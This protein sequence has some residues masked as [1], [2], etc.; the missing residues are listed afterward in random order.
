MR[1]QT[2]PQTYRATVWLT[3]K[4]RVSFLFNLQVILKAKHAGR[5]LG[6]L[7]SACHGSKRRS[8][9]MKLSQMYAEKYK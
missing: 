2:N 3:K 6:Y 7:H 5:E 4:K 8:A 1:T 9:P